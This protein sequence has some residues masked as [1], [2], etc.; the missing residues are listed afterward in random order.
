[1]DALQRLFLTDVKRQGD[2]SNRC[3]FL[4]KN[5]CTRYVVLKGHVN[6]WVRWESA[7]LKAIFHSEEPKHHHRNFP[8]RFK[9]LLLEGMMIDLNIMRAI[10]L[11]ELGNKKDNILDQLECAANEFQAEMA[12]VKSRADL[13]SQ[14]RRH[15][16]DELTAVK[17][18]I[19]TR[20]LDGSTALG[21]EYRALSASKPPWLVIQRSIA[22]SCFKLCKGCSVCNLG[23]PPRER[24]AP[25][26]LRT[27]AKYQSHPI[28]SPLA[29]LATWITGSRAPE[30]RKTSHE[31]HPPRKG[32]HAN[33]RE[34]SAYRSGRT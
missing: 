7:R 19:D 21:A 24:P 25:K 22:N 4:T 20:Y 9:C 8:H 31:Q 18:R 1:V 12:R 27:V 14:Q 15:T 26:V 23:V 32:K 3:D 30:G 11:K 17:Q 10:R 28:Q 33:S 5:D 16:L 2:F 29:C 6:E 34:K 13:E